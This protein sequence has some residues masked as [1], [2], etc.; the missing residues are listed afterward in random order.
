MRSSNPGRGSVF[1]FQRR[2]DRIWGTHI[3]LFKGYRR[4]FPYVSRQRLQVER[5]HPSGDEVNNE[6]S[7]T[8]SPLICLMAWTGVNLPFR[9]LPLEWENTL[10]TH[11][12]Q[13]TKLH[14]LYYNV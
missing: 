12:Q 1:S 10:R 6:W 7:Y 14:S 4:S 8:S 5:S 3:L 13:R 2:P 9:F 11:V